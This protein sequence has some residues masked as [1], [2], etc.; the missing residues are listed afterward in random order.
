MLIFGRE[1][2]MEENRLSDKL[3]SLE[4]IKVLS[5]LIGSFYN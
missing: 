3:A 2:D 5:S 1:D 4:I